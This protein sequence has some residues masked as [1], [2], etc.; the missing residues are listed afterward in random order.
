[1]NKNVAIN[2]QFKSNKKRSFSVN[3]QDNI[4][5]NNKKSLNLSEYDK[6]KFFK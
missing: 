4:I 1:M 3:L 2:N 5:K 6:K